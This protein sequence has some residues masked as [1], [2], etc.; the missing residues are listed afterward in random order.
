MH[1]GFSWLMGIEMPYMKGS[2]IIKENVQI[3]SIRICLTQ[4]DNKTI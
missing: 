2:S 3:V 4:N 1:W